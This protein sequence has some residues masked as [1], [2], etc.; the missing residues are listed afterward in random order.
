MEYWKN[1]MQT[2]N[3]THI[4]WSLKKEFKIL[5]LC[6]VLPRLVHTLR[7]D[8][9]EKPLDSVNGCMENCKN[10]AKECEEY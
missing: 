4:Y 9:E 3:K 5:L 8:Y 1:E 10:M 6:K 2:K 7:K